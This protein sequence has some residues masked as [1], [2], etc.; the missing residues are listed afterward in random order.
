MYNRSDL[1][2]IDV[3]VFCSL[4][5][6]HASRVVTSLRIVK[7]CK[8]VYRKQF[9]YIFCYPTFTLTF[10]FTYIVFSLFHQ[11]EYKVLRKSSVKILKSNL[12]QKYFKKLITVNMIDYESRQVKEKKTYTCYRIK[13]IKYVRQKCQIHKKKY[14]Y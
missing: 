13:N 7:F 8:H 4:K 9:I 3:A 6:S 1:L 12:K 10:P 11:K 5:N 14:K 2:F